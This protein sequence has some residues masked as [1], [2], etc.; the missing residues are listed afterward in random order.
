MPSIKL[1]GNV[2]TASLVRNSKR[3]EIHVRINGTIHNQS[4]FS[5]EYHIE[6]IFLKFISSGYAPTF[7]LS[8]EA[9]ILK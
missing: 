3:T 7:C 6:G 1:H 4:E 2:G 9:D 5:A 8:Y